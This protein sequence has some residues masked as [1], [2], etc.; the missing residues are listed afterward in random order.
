MLEFDEAKH[1]YT[2]DGREL[3]SVTTILKNC[4]CMKALPFYTDAGAANGKRRHLLTELYDNRTL[5]WGTIASEDMPYLEGWITARKDLN[6]TVEPSEIEVQLYHPILGYA[7]TADRICLVDGVRTI[8]DIKN[9]APAKWNVLQLILYG[10]AYS[11]LFEQ[12]LPE[13]L[14][15]YLKKNGKYK[16]QKHDYSDQ[17][18]AIAAARIQNWK[19][20]K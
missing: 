5:D 20:I 9:G 12:S 17:S 7:G 14:C 15:V 4:G 2:L 10:L 11:V 16:A 8:L 1:I 19:G 6:I 18:Y 13:L 3:P